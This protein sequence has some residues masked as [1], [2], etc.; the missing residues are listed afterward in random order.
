MGDAVS[1]E[2]YSPLQRTRYRERLAEDLETFDRHLQRAEF[3]DAGSI[4]LELE[5]NLIDS[6]GQPAAVGPRVL[7]SL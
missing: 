5:L 2:R 3:D 1:T 6:A 4:G 7:E